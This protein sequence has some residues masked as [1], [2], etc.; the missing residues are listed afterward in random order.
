[1]ELRHLEHFVA[2]AREGSFTRAAARLHL[3]QSTLSVSIRSLERELGGR[4]FERT[5]R[6]VELTDAGR[7]L[8]PEAH[9]ALGAVDAARDAVA[10]VQ[11]G[12]RGTVRLGIMQSLT[13]ID[14]ATTLSRYH[15]EL[16]HVEIIPSTSPGGSAEL[17]SQVLAGDLDLAFAALPGHYPGGVTVHRLASEPLMLACLEDHAFASRPVVPLADLDGERFVDVP[18]GWGTRAS[19]DRLFAQTGLRR[20]IT[21]EVTDIPTVV[22]LVRAGFGCAFV[23]TSLISG[24]RTDS[25][26]V[27]PV[28]PAPLFEVSLVTASGRRPSAAARAFIDLVLAT[29]ADRE[30]APDRYDTL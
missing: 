27:R 4:L 23:S 5:T 20:E 3:V 9:T 7:A 29:H 21:V 12:V 26:A 22:N 11:N 1:M 18:I 24:S 25:L 30:S 8:L 17:V 6:Q 19:V 15:R 13:L 16:P 2:V 10:A 14:L 28:H